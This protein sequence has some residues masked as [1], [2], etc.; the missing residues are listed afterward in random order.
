MVSY[1]YLISKDPT[2]KPWDIYDR[3]IIYNLKVPYKTC[4]PR[5]GGK[6]F[7]RCVTLSSN[8]P[9]MIHLPK[10][11]TFLLDVMACYSRIPPDKILEEII[12]LETMYK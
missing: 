9:K 3:F 10:T 8:D 5:K 1:S 7:D 12:T 4:E 6:T 11:F 2:A